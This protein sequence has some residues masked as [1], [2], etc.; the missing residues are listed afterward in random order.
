MT[1]DLPPDES[2]RI[3]ALRRYGVLDTVAEQAYDDIAKLAAYIS[4]T[5]IA[6]VSL[7]D[8][9]R[10]WFKSKVGI[11]ATETP[12]DVAFCAHAIL[13]PDEPMVVPDATAD[14][15]F[16]HN[17]L[18]TGDLGVRFYLGVPL[19]TPDGFAIGTLCVIDRKPREPTPQQIEMMKALARQVV[20]Q[21]ELNRHIAEVELAA[22]DREMYLGQLERYQH[23]LE[24]ANAELREMGR[25]DAL[26]GARNRAAFDRRLGEEVYRSH[27]YKSPL[28]LLM[29][30]VDHFKEYNDAF[31]H[32]AGDEALKQLTEI[33]TNTSRPTDYV[34]RYGGEEFTV[35][36]AATSGDGA[37]VAAS[38][39]RHAVESAQFPY[40]QLTISIGVATLEPKVGN[41]K[42][43]I[44]AA[45]GAL[46]AA[47][48]AGR[49][50]VERAAVKEVKK[51]A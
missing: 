20:T 19:V 29:I 18:V 14:E 21:L 31:G 43:L 38:R 40:R 33:L 3:K 47:K 13:T 36:L 22:T 44:A 42:S 5:P 6:L 51:T 26:T 12:R 16:A 45:D 30:D 23:E 41:P 46:Y 15:R 9:Q 17:P 50:R 4:G 28:S 25:T 37:Y 11:T 24:E 34:A 49:N 32:P 1:P 39:L 7:V 10:Q 35:L 48:A 2:Q 8:A 27:R